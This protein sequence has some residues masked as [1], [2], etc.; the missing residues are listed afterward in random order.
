MRT[1]LRPQEPGRSSFT[2]AIFELLL[3]PVRFDLWQDHLHIPESCVFSLCL[4]GFG[5]PCP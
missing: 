1:S 5:A 4:N 2:L 3:A